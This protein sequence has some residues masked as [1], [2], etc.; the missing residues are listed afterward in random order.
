M[1]VGPLL[2]MFTLPPVWA[3]RLAAAVTKAPP[4]AEEPMSPLPEPLAP[5]DRL[6]VV[7]VSD[8]PLPCTIPPWFC[9]PFVPSLDCRLIVPPD[10]APAIVICPLPEAAS[11]IVAR[12]NVPLLPAEEALG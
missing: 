8:P 5:S 12:L 4:G 6:I 10:T 1:L 2:L 7:A 11:G 3:T 9:D